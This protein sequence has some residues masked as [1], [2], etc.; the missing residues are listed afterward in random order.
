M[1]TEGN[2]K[3]TEGRSVKEIPDLT[4]YCT[5]QDVA[6]IV[7]VSWQT[8]YKWVKEGRT[9]ALS[10]GPRSGERNRIF[11]HE[12]DVKALFQPYQPSTPQAA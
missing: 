12:D 11:I 5:I 6:E 4:Q 1:K 10:V 3:R 8:V 7:G 2:F 9:P